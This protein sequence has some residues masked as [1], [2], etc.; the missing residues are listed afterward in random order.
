MLL[1]AFMLAASSAALIAANGS[2]APRERARVPAA[3]TNTVAF[4]AAGDT[5]TLPAAWVQATDPVSPALLDPHEIL[6]IAPF[7]VPDEAHPAVC[8]GDA[9]PAKAL[10]AM[11]ADD[12][13]VWIVEWT[14]LPPP[15]QDRVPTA[16]ST[17]SR[18]TLFTPEQ[19][20][21]RQCV[22]QAYP[23]LI[24]RE[25]LF[26]DSGRVFQVFVAHGNRV[27][28]DRQREVY[29]WLDSLRFANT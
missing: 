8:V 5:V 16:S 15:D 12:A 7:E 4:D 22:D 9:P 20:S 18:P 14:P 2:H 13:F 19:F 24:G 3:G 26:N 1:F 28:P 10:H 23:D 17:D 11:T 6:A 27:S 29:Q 25:L 21:P